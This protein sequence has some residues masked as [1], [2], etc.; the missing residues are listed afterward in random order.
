MTML[1][2]DR[3]QRIGEVGRG[4]LSPAHLAMEATKP[5]TEEDSGETKWVPYPWLRLLNGK[6]MK[7][8]R[9]RQEFANTRRNVGTHFLI[10]EAPVRHGK[11]ELGSVYFPSWWLGTFPNDRVILTGNNAELAESFSRR[12]RDL[13]R[14]HGRRLFGYDVGVSSESSAVHRWDLN[15]PHRGGLIAVGVGSPP[16]GRGGHLIVVDDPIKSDLEAYSQAYRDSLWRWWQFSIRSRLEPGGVV[17]IIMSRWHEDDLVGRLL[18]RQKEADHQ[19]AIRRKKLLDAGNLTELERESIQTNEEDVVDRWE[20]VHLPAL[21]EPTRE[22]VEAWVHRRRIADPAFDR[23]MRETGATTSEVFNVDEW[24]D[25]LGRSA[26]EALEPRRYDRPTLVR[27]RDSPLGVGPIAF[28]ALYQNNPTSA[29]GEIIDVE[30]FKFTDELPTDPA[31]KWVRAWDLAATEKEQYK[32]D[33]DWT[34]GALIGRT[35]GGFIYVA[36]VCRTRRNSGAVEDS[37]TVEAFMRAKCYEDQARLGRRI[38]TS[39]PQD[40]GAAGKITVAHYKR[41]VLAGFDVVGDP[42]RGDKVARAQPWANQVAAGNVTLVAGDWNYD[43]IEECRGFPKGDHDDQVDAVSR[44][45]NNLAGFNR[46][47]ASVIV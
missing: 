28:R 43:F 3:E 44:G 29:K 41:E 31:I 36:D 16:T 33:P 17:V 12:S 6:L 42:E 38:R 7:L 24:R 45:H 20:V 30:K 32:P 39:I 34:A 40:P 35:P 22:E 8:A 2:R 4:L 46:P 10:V 27:L 37:S 5:L 47:K 1:D 15:K 25:V 11:S 14:D 26:G 9:A 13:I 19:D 23:Y 21:A 18:K